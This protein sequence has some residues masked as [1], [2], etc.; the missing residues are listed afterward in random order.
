LERGLVTYEITRTARGKTT[1]LEE[2]PRTKMLDRLRKLRGSAM[3]GVSGRTQIKYRVHYA[4]RKKEPVSSKA[5]KR[6]GQPIELACRY[7]VTGDERHGTA[8][9]LHQDLVLVSWFLATQ[10][11][12]RQDGA[13]LP[14]QYHSAT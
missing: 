9:Q 6:R 14:R 2:G 5:S 3:R 7:Y 4:L 1:V 13:L 11:C 12:Y 8:R 10:L